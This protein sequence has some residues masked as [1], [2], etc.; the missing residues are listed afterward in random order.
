MLNVA[1]LTCYIEYIVSPALHVTKIPEQL[2]PD[3]AAPLLCGMFAVICRKKPYLYTVSAGIAMYSSIMKTKS[4]PGDYLA[5][6]GAGGGLGHMYVD[7]LYCQFLLNL[8]R[9]GIQIA[10]KKGLQVIAIDR[11]AIYPRQ[12]VHIKL[13]VSLLHSGEKKKQLCLSL[14]AIE[15]LDYREVDIVQATK[16]RTGLGVHA[17]I[18]TA[19]GERAYE[20]SM[21]MLRPLGTLVCVGIPSVPF[22]LPATPFDMI[23]K[24]LFR[25]ALLRTQGII[26]N[27]VQVLLLLVTRQEQ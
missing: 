26:T 10:T 3:S 13:T 11:Y 2:S 24:G 6:I 8:S 20:Q 21:Q 25:W 15:F 19:N 9:R 1:R 17:V 16:A 14:G 7:G 22:R 4:R 23:V 12:I 18:C 5:I 27:T